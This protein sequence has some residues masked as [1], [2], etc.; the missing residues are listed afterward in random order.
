MSRKPRVHFP[1]AV[2]HVISPGAGGENTKQ[3]KPDTLLFRSRDHDEREG[4]YALKQYEVVAVPGI[5][6]RAE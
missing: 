2:Y 5:Q 6:R 1:E 4:S 3:S